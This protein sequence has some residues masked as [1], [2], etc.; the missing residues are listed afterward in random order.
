VLLNPLNIEIV[1][2]LVLETIEVV[3]QSGYTSP[4][5]S[6]P[7]CT[8]STKELIFHRQNYSSHFLLSNY[9]IYFLS[10]VWVCIL[11]N[12]VQKMRAF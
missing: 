8:Y 10:K 12:S 2:D 7:S 1:S 11:S 5:S 6:I 9:C 3:G 4:T